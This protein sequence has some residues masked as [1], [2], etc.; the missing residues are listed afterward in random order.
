MLA[1]SRIVVALLLVASATTFAAGVAI[2]RSGHHDA[3]AVTGAAVTNPTAPEGSAARETGEKHTPAQV[4]EAKSEQLFG[5][6]TESNTVI[7]FVVA[8]SLLLAIGALAIRS[9]LIL[10]SIAVFG[11]GAV[12]FD[13]REVLHQLDES[14][15]GVATLAAL[16]AALHLALALLVAT[17]AFSAGRVPSP[18]PLPHA[19]A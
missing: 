13:V 8:I 19:P 11:L 10:V 9:P 5:V 17:L 2:E 18:A 4:T 3:S 15:T 12:A 1:R 7:A 6:N 16:I 14:R